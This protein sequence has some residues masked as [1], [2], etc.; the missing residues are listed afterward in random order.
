MRTV[1]NDLSPQQIVDW[2]RAQSKL[3][4]REA[5]RLERFHKLKP[6]S[7]LK[8]EATEYDEIQSSNGSVT[9]DQ[10]EAR[11]R[12][13]NAR[14]STLAAEFGV[15]QDLIETALKQPQFHHIGRGWWAL[16][17]N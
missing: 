8:I 2:Y 11:L 15:S 6:P 3:Y 10:L 12:K 17:S 7:K 5:D 9:T 1:K 13:K 4:A 14:A 16:K